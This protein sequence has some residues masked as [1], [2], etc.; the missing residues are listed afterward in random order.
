MG[1][2]CT[3]NPVVLGKSRLVHEFPC[4]AQTLLL[5]KEEDFMIAHAYDDVEVWDIYARRLVWRVS[6]TGSKYS[7]LISHV[8]LSEDNKHLITGYPA[9]K[10]ICVWNIKERKLAFILEPPT[11]AP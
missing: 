3:S 11:K 4:Q 5:T 8:A 10:T 9:S 6:D 2:I 7:R 1:N